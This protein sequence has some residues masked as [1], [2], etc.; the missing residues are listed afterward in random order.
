[1]QRDNIN[2]DT[3]K[4]ISVLCDF[5]NLTDSSIQIWNETIFSF[6]KKKNT[7]LLSCYL[8]PHHSS[9][10]LNHLFY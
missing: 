10:E 6:Y 2:Y 1:M 8:C 7:A 9:V 4:T 3:S 5:L